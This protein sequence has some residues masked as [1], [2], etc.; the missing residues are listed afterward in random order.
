MKTHYYFV[1]SILVLFVSCQPEDQP[2]EDLSKDHYPAKFEK[3]NLAEFPE[4]NLIDTVSIIENVE[5]VREEKIP[6]ERVDAQI[7]AY[8]N[9]SVN[10]NRIRYTI[11]QETIDSL[12]QIIPLYNDNQYNHL[13]LSYFSTL[14]KD[15]CGRP[16]FAENA[17]S[18]VN[19]IIEIFT[20]R[21]NDAT[22]V[23]LL[24]DKTGSME[25][26]IEKV[27]SGLIQLK[28]LLVNYSDVKLAIASYGDKNYH[29]NLWYN[30]SDLSYDLDQIDEFIEG[31]STMGN[32]DT[33]ESVNDAIVKTVKEM[34]WTPGNQRM[35][36]VIGD[37]PSLKVPQSDYSQK[38]VVAF[39]DS[40]DVTFNLYPIIISAS[41][42]GTPDVSP[43]RDFA[44]V[45]PNPASDIINFSTTESGYF[46]YNIFDMNGKLAL[47]NYSFIESNLAINV[48]S[49]NNG[50]YLLQ[51]FDSKME[52][53]FT[54]Q[55]IVSH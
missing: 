31:Y 2:I 36:L 29:E 45:F 18:I 52:Y 32:A 10:Y 3:I 27:K 21:L 33:P 5:V 35:I 44:N 50:N 46:T 20:T 53:Y 25:D 38:D 41:P 48:Q 42:M 22:D 12:N 24:I 17:D 40:M 11:S 14:S 26:D 54:S 16:F 8:S 23:V 37:A 39:C 30:R 13:A 49:L 6:T 4:L 15:L 51:A 47:S 28:E 43:K 7:L 9:D 34:N 1:C 19:R 55:I